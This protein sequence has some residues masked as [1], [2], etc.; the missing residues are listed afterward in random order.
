M[1]N[2]RLPFVVFET[3]SEC[4]QDCLYCYN[5]WKRPGDSER[6]STGFRQTLGTLKSLFRQAEVSHVT[7]SG[8]EPFL[9]ERFLEL[10]LACRM[11]GKSVTIIT[12]GTCASAEDYRS[13]KDIGVGV[14]EL[15]L[16]SAHPE[17]HDRLTRSAGSWQKVTGSIDRIQELDIPV[18]AVIVL[19]TVN[20]PD[21]GDTLDF[22]KER[23]ITRIMLNRF[24]VGGRGIR[25]WRH[26]SLSKQELRRAFSL[27][28]RKAE[29]DQLSISANVCT[30]FCILTPKD[31]PH[32]RTV[33]CSP[34]IEQRPVTLDALGNIRLCNHSPTVLGN[35]HSTSLEQIFQSPY[36]RRFAQTVPKMCAGCEQFNECQGG[37]RAAGEQL[38]GSLDQGDPL[39][40]YEELTAAQPRSSA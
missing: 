6:R 21:L 4:N 26:L 5:I 33:S 22:L 29:E 40:C 16:L 10:V 3:T 31:Y 8:G 20:F 28:D 19:T 15:P 11:R 34:R 14:F 2:T 32:I 30:P 37:C 38:W 9:S 39:L 13:L 35:I 18:V 36:L 12:N 1:K 7:F 24:N 23:G 27:A 25:E 17:V